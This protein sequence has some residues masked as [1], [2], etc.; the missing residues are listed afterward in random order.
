M[1]AHAWERFGPRAIAR[2]GAMYRNAG[3]RLLAASLLAAAAASCD[4]GPRS[5][6]D[7]VGPP[8]SIIGLNASGTQPIAPNGTVQIAFDRFLNGFTVLRQSISLRDSSGQVVEAP[9][10]A[11]EPV[12]R[13]VSVGNSGASGA[14]NRWLRADQFYTL[15]LGVP[16]RGAELG[17]VGSV[18]GATLLPTATRLFGFYARAN[19]S[20]PVAVPT[21]EFCRDVLP[22]MQ[23]KC[24]GS[25]CHGGS[26]GASLS[27]TAALG[28]V[29]DRTEGVRAAIGELS[30][31]ANTGPRA[32]AATP[33]PRVFGLDALVIDVGNPGN[34]WIMHKILSGAFGSRETEGHCGAPAVLPQPTI[35]D[36]RPASA[37]ERARLANRISGRSMPPGD[38]VNAYTWAEARRLSAWISQGAR[39]STCAPC[40]P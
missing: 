19:V 28:L 11:Y 12:T 18:D 13:T 26:V 23:A 21:I 31:E 16:E 6:E 25:S 33:A 38:S 20:S 32:T 15:G 14:G 29:L 36:V 9:V 24:A 4:A 3:S 40:A 8:I 27:A 30:R 39:I 2:M 1:T 7:D 5:D 34:S 35:A 10:V 17:G 37:A 22:P